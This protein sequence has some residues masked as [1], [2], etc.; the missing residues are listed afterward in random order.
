MSISS[1]HFELKFN[2]VK[3]ESDTK[4]RLIVSFNLINW[5]KYCMLFLTKSRFCKSPLQENILVSRK[6][7]VFADYS[8]HIIATLEVRM[9]RQINKFVLQIFS[10][11]NLGRRI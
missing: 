4:H 2:S 8:V 1:E 11:F 9:K 5:Q 3:L 6:T 10:N 7:Y